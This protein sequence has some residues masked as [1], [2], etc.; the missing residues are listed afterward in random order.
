MSKIQKR[1]QTQKAGHM[2][3]EAER[4]FIQL[5]AKGHPELPE[6]GTGEEGFSSKAFRRAVALLTS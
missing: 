1:R 3:A 5:Q 2:K 4:E 6:A